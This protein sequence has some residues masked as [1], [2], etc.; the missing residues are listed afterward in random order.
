[1]LGIIVLL[2]LYWSLAIQL[3]FNV[4]RLIK[5]LMAVSYFNASRLC[6]GN[7]RMNGVVILLLVCSALV[8][9]ML[10]KFVMLR[11]SSIGRST[12]VALHLRM[13]FLGVYQYYQNNSNDNTQFVSWFGSWSYIQYSIRIDTHVFSIRCEPQIDGDK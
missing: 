3:P 4:W 2:D 6:V 8:I 7:A 9:I 13:V 11:M 12:D 10:T 1:M 5:I